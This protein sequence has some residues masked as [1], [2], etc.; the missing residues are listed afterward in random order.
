MNDDWILEVLADL[1]S[2]A[3]QNGLPFLAG[4]LGDARKLAAIELAARLPKRGGASEPLPSILDA[5]RSRN[6]SGNLDS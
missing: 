1:K 6:G 4:H 2:F 5:R 3:E